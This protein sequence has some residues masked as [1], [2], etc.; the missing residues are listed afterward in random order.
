[1][2]VVYE[3]KRQSGKTT[4][5]ATEAAARLACGESIVILCPT[6]AGGDIIT[7]M[8]PQLEPYIRSLA[9]EMPPRDPADPWMGVNGTD[10]CMFKNL[11]M[12]DCEYQKERF[13]YV[14][15][16]P[17]Q[18]IFMTRTIGPDAAES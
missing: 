18:R 8:Y 16:L 15:S 1:M 6:K 2:I 13:D 5:L 3:G 17:W 14:L 9:A 10:Y 12:N 11:F 7:G 4:E